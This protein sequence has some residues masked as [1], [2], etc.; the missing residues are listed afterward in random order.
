MHQTLSL[1]GSDEKATDERKQKQKERN[2]KSA[3]LK[4]QHFS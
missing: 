3:K 2:I 4:A 1:R